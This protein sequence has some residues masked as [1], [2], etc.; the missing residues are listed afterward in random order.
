MSHPS[1]S[2]VVSKKKAITK[3]GIKLKKKARKKGGGGGESKKM[4]ARKVGA[5][6][7]MAKEKKKKIVETLEGRRSGKHLL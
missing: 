2:S 7:R 6:F 5:N 4:N 1:S 3:S